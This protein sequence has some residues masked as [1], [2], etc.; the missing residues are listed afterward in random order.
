MVDLDITGGGGDVGE[1]GVASADLPEFRAAARFE[2]KHGHKLPV[3]VK[4]LLLQTQL[5]VDSVLLEANN[6]ADIINSGSW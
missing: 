4:L 5:V 3:S 6:Q 2:V 1:D